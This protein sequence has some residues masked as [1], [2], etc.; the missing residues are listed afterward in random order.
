MFNHG[1]VQS[2]SNVNPNT[3]ALYPF[4]GNS[5]DRGRTG[6]TLASVGAITYPTSPSPTNGATWAQFGNNIY[7]TAPQALKTAMMSGSFWAIEFDVNMKAWAQ[8]SNVALAIYNVGNTVGQHLDFFTTPKVMRWAAT[9]GNLDSPTLAINTNYRLALTFDGTTRKI[10]V[11]GLLGASTVSN[12]QFPI[13]GTLNIGEFYLIIG[14]GFLGTMKN[15]RFS[16]YPN[17]TSVPK[18]FPTQQ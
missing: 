3:I 8:T 15:L 4:E 7:H 16:L 11:N 6:Y 2:N 10:Y 13:I 18:S 5:R 12:V 14:A 1:L 17:A 9:V